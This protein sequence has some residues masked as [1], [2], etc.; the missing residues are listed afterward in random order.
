MDDQGVENAAIL[1][2]SLGEEQASEVFR[3]LA[4]KEVQR[5]GETIAKLRT[6]SRERVDQVLQKF[7]DE[8][9]GQSML[10]DDNDEYVRS[11]LKRALGDALGLSRIGVNLTTLPPGKESAMR[12]WHTHEDEMVYVLEGEVVL[13]TDAGETGREDHRMTVADQ[14][15][16]GQRRAGEQ[17]EQRISGTDLLLGQPGNPGRRLRHALTVSRRDEPCRHI[18]R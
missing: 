18:R 16:R 2:M 17:R 13:V 5:M 4:P 6:V 15:D 10:V 1:L 9:G 3:H 7:N 12:H 8:A 11:V 14:R